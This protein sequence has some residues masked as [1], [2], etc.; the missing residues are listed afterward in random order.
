[1]N[2]EF[3]QGKELL[4]SRY[5]LAGC[6]FFYSGI[7]GSSTFPML[8]GEN[9]IDTYIYENGRFGFEKEADWGLPVKG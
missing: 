6:D 8:I 5:L 1:M 4:A 9:F 3:L 2:D 7:S